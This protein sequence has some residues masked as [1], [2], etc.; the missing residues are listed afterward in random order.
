MNDKI[1]ILV[2]HPPRYPVNYQFYNLLGKIVDL[3]IWQFGE[4][5]SD[6]PSWHY[7]ELKKLNTNINITVLGSGKDSIKNQFNIFNYSKDLK[8]LNPDIVLSVAFW[9]PS[10]YISLIKNILSFKFVILTD[11]IEETEKAIQ[12]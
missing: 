5:P 6:H 4:Y 2:L 10:L 8:K 3:H 7:N 1:K 12:K 9:M 11:A